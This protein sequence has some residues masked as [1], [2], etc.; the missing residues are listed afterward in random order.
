M[1]EDTNG[2]GTLDELDGPSHAAILLMALGE[3]KAAS[4]LKHM[5]PLEVQSLGEAMSGIEG[6][7]Q[8]Q[9]GGTL[10]KFI[11]NVKNESSLG[12]GSQEYLRR[13][14]TRA[15]GLDKAN[16]VM[17]QINLEGGPVGL[18]SLKWMSP[19]VV[20]KIIANEHPQIIAIVLAH[21]DRAQGGSVMNLLPESMRTDVLVRVAKLDII[22]PAALQELNDIIQR[23]FE[24]NSES[25][26]TGVG[27]VD[28]AAEIL[29][30]V[31]KEAEA[32][33]LEAL[34]ELDSELSKQIQEKM[35]IFDNLIAVDD[36]GMQALL[37][38]V[39]TDQLVVALKGAS[40][41]LR[42]KIF[43]NMSQRASELLRDDLEAK[44]PMRL[45][46]VED[47]Q[48]QV[49]TVAMRLAEDGTISLGGKGDDF[50]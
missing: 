35:F 18:E 10:D 17:G 40:P 21:L 49:L 3:E 13:T 6:V 9:I 39:S 22:H 42:E 33:V 26:L 7:T 8:D 38:E 46:E 2:S 25:E 27:G 28:V 44:G 36:R 19:R 5:E 11:K 30:G 24:E 31:S 37:R 16:S 48:K 41:E 12:H 43:G 32:S 47:A 50:V 14:L 1:A 4:V 45:A 29:N 20:A 23:R 34:D 15:L